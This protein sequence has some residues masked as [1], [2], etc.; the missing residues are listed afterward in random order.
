MF[1]WSFIP[2]IPTA[3]CKNPSLKSPIG[4]V[5]VN[6]DI[7]VWFDRLSFFINAVLGVMCVYG[8]VQ[9]IQS[10]IRD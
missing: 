7:C 3:S 6:M 10:A 2:A 1:N 9:Q 5:S 4:N 8:C